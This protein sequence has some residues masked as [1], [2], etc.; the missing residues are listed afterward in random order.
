[1][2]ERGPIDVVEKE[3]KK[4]LIDTLQEYVPSIDVI[5]HQE[6][7]RRLVQEVELATR[8]L[9]QEVELVRNK[10]AIDTFGF[11]K[12]VE[13]FKGQIW[14]LFRQPDPHRK[15]GSID[16]EREKWSV[17]KEFL[18]AIKAFND[19][20]KEAERVTGSS[21]G[22]YKEYYMGQINEAEEISSGRLLTHGAPTDVMYKILERGSLCSITEQE[23]MYKEAGRTHPAGHA[24]SETH[25]ICFTVDGVYGN[26]TSSEDR[27]RANVILIFSENHILDRRQYV[28]FDGRHVFDERYS[29]ETEESPGLRID[30]LETPFMILVTEAEKDRLFDFLVNQSAFTNILREQKPE[31]QRRWLEEHVLVTPKISDYK[32]GLGEIKKKFFQITKL[33]PKKGYVELTDTKARFMTAQ[34]KTK[35]FFAFVG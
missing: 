30:L 28:D 33:Q 14:D 2:S 13:E 3:Q 8:E 25:D 9:S 32:K 11:T 31:E 6:V 34:R 12:K 24:S 26:F 7:A 29:G 17:T 20:I 18:Q 16:R 15:Y 4:E 1:M 10:P 21:L 22:E 35:Q 23:K 5:R 27:F 19:R